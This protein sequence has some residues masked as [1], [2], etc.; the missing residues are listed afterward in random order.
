MNYETFKLADRDSDLFTANY[1]VGRTKMVP[2]LYHAVKTLLLFSE[3]NWPCPGKA[4]KNS[5]IIQCKKEETQ[6]HIT[7]MC[8]FFEY[9]FR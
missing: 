7:H 4:E 5:R 1:L 6:S 9:F 3:S 2:D 8:D